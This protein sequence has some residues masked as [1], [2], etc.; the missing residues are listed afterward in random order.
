M[1]IE[2]L[3]IEFRYLAL[4]I[5]LLLEGEAVLLLAAFLAQRGYLQL[6][7]VI[8]IGFFVTYTV[9]QFFF[10]IG[11]NKGKQFL[12]KRPNW[13]L[14]VEK[15]KSLMAGNLNLLVLGFRFMYGLRVVLPV[16]IGMSGIS[17][18]RFAVLNLFSA[19]LWTVGLGLAGY[20]FGHLAEALLANVRKYEL[21]IFLGVLILGAGIWLY[22]RYAPKKLA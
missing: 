4:V 20:L 19:I 8:L 2:S 17:P 5:G 18:K 14:K 6:P 12:A 16:V 3:L 10:W 11:H 22:S 1:S 7:A 15:A 9:D 13:A 21:W